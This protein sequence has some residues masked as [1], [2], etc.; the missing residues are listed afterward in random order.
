MSWLTVLSLGIVGRRVRQR[1][2]L[3]CSRRNAL[4]AADLRKT[5]KVVA[6]CREPDGRCRNW[7]VQVGSGKVINADMVWPVWASA[8]SLP[9]QCHNRWAWQPPSPRQLTS[10]FSS[11]TGSLNACHSFKSPLAPGHK[12]RSPPEV[13]ITQ[14]QTH[15]SPRATEA[16][17]PLCSAPG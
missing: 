11:A 1:F 12:K 4:P 16:Q 13:S 10:G 3:P 17:L 6:P 7:A 9:P 14:F 5:G 2:G 8:P 15:E